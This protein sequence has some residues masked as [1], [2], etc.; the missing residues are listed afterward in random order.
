MDQYARGHKHIQYCEK[1]I[2]IENLVYKGYSHGYRYVVVNERRNTLKLLISTIEASIGTRGVSAVYHE[3]VN[4][5]DDIVK[6]IEMQSLSII[7][8][9]LRALMLNMKVININYQ[10]DLES[11]VCGVVTAAAS[12]L[13]KHISGSTYNNLGCEEDTVCF[14]ENTRNDELTLEDRVSSDGKILLENILKDTKY[15]WMLTLQTNDW[16]IPEANPYY[17][18][19]PLNF[20]DKSGEGVLKTFNL[21]TAYDTARCS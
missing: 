12:K 13:R 6:L 10:F 17:S 11:D 1:F 7:V 4:K 3:L 19:D 21:K 8:A 20:L 9:R 2:N 14:H 16:P 18:I 5:K 15:E